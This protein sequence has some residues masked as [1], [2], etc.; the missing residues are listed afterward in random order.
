MQRVLLHLWSNKGA[1]TTLVESVEQYH[2]SRLKKG[3][4]S[5]PH[6]PAI[7]HGAWLKAMDRW[8]AVNAELELLRREQTSSN[9]SS[10]V[11]S[12]LSDDDSPLP[13]P[14]SSSNSRGA[15]V[16]WPDEQPGEVAGTDAPDATDNTGADTPDCWSVDTPSPSSQ[17]VLNPF[18]EADAAYLAEIRESIRPEN[19]MNSVLAM[20]SS[21]T[22]P[23]PPSPIEFAPP[24]QEDD[25]VHEDPYLL[26]GIDEDCS[27]AQVR[28]AYLRMSRVYH[29]DKQI[30]SMRVDAAAKMQRITR[31]Y[32]II[33]LFRR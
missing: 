14:I 1:A 5:K 4:T 16:D 27:D 23:A 15:Y 25:C 2:E 26:F 6:N 22:L 11:T 32:R 8:D 29:P 19:D 17:H 3:A 21:L 30:P 20:P 13:E 33:Q 12:H 9:T 10:G 31:A 28:S 18:E 7:L 24:A